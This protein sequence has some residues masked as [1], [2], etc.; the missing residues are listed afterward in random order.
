MMTG[1]QAKHRMSLF[2]EMV[3]EQQC[4]L[5]EKARP[6]FDHPA[7]GLG[8]CNPVTKMYSTGNHDKR[9]RL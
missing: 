6:I 3:A 4:K 2:K 1:S 7:L 8:C 9:K 5:D